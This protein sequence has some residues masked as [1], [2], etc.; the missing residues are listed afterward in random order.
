MVKRI[1][2]A[3]ASGR[4]ITAKRKKLTKRLNKKRDV[5]A[6]AL[7]KIDSMETSLRNMR[8]RRRR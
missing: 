8:A 4:L 5:I 7:V 3:R 2:R 1:S 6:R